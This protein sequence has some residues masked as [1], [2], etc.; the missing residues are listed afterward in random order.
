MLAL[1]RHTAVLVAIAVAVAARASGVLAQ[2]PTRAA[3]GLRD[4][5]V[6]PDDPDAYALLEQM[7]IEGNRKTRR[8]IVLRE[9]GLALGDTVRLADLDEVLERTQRLLINTGL[10]SEAEVLV[11]DLDPGGQR[12]RL[13]VV[14]REKWYIYP[15]VGV[16]L[17]DRNFN[18]WWT[19]QN[20]DLSRLNFAAALRHRNITGRADRLVLQVQT[21]YTRKTELIYR[22]PYIDRAKVLGLEIGALVDRNR[23]WQSR[24]VGGEQ[25]FYGNDTTAVLRR[26]RFRVGI[27]ARP[28]IYLSHLLAV[29]WQ[30]ARADSALALEVSPD[31]FGDGRTRQAYRGLFY[32]LT[33]D[34]RD[35]RA[36]PLRGNLLRFRAHKLGLGAGDDV[37]RLNV[38]LAYARYQPLG[39]RLNLAVEAK[40]KTDVQRARVPYFNRESLGFG[41]DFLRGYQFYVVDGLDFAFAKTTLRARVFEGDVRVPYAPVK[42]LNQVP[43][44]VFVGVHGDVGGMR[45]PFD[46]PGNVLANRTLVGYGV[47]LYANAFY[48]QVISVEYTRNDL[49]EWGW[50]V[51]FDMGL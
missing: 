7:V 49:G 11:S 34:N 29:E 6:L 12:L 23:E 43:L 32:Q 35:L 16:D 48:G 2:A 41:D 47:G 19:E 15:S 25:R 26:R 38:S 22:I 36:F 42:V 51:G 46:A 1:V 4:T 18:I 45:D 27:S 17:A 40:A 9:T 39:A 20:R 44:R 30:V 3:E 33:F 31:F 13:R 10:F 37:N 28:G 50:F 21:G 5:L 14:V 8:P 24:T